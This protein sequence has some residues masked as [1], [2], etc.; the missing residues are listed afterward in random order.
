MAEAAAT[1]RAGPVAWAGQALLYGLF[2]AFIGVF[3][4]WPTYRPLPADQALL[5]LSFGHTGK[6]VA[7]CRQRDPAELAKLPPNMRAPLDCPRERSP[8]T[9]ELDIDGRTVLREVLPPSGLKRDGASSIYRRIA[10]PAGTHRIAVRLQDD[11]RA[12]GFTHRHEQA[13]TLEPAQIVVI[14]FDAATQRITVR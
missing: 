14:D 2:A 12:G 1:D 3:A 6:P 7:E 10:L 5:K 11:V 9:V 8:V 4:A 13:V